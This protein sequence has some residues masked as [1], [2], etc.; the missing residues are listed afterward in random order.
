MRKFLLAASASV[1]FSVGAS[2]QTT[3]FSPGWY[4]VEDCAE[5][6]VMQA[7]AGDLEAGGEA[8]MFIAPGE[9][10][11]AF[12]GARGNIFVF[13]SFGRMSAM[14]PAQCLTRVPA[15]GRP[16]RV[17]NEIVSMDDTKIVAGATVWMLRYNTAGRTA[18]VRLA[19]GRELEIPSESV[20]TLFNSFDEVMRGAT[21]QAVHY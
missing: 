10:V 11:L 4:I 3:G 8:E 5:F 17:V 20:T 7:S 6:F 13:E 9:V 2:A 15:V 19:S 12:E 18:V 16:A 1:L 14:R 21:F